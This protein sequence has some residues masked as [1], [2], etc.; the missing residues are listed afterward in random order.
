MHS[1][2]IIVGST[3]S[4]VVQLAYALQ[5]A[6]VAGVGLVLDRMK[7]SCVVGVLIRTHTHTLHVQ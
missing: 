3:G 6:L 1:F 5:R 2:F 4:E 7:D